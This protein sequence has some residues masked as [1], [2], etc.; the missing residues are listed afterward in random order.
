MQQEVPGL[1][2]F[3]DFFNPQRCENILEESLLIHDKLEKEANESN[4]PINS[5][6][7]PQPDFVKSEKH[8]LKSNES[9]LRLTIKETTGNIKGEYFPR[10]GEDGHVLAYFRGNENLPRFVNT[11]LPNIKALI[12]DNNI[13]TDDIEDSWRLTMNFYKN[14]SGL[15]SGFPFHVDIPANGVVTMILNTHREATFQITNGNKTIDLHLP[16]GALLI[17]SGESRYTWKHRVLPSE[18]ESD[19]ENYIERISL[20]LGVK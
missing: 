2:L 19:I 10:Y 7:I 14:I 1:Y 18:S 9:F 15:V 8:N 11:F 13:I 6:N 12:N 17:L 20:V 16:V 3:K 4:T 5:A